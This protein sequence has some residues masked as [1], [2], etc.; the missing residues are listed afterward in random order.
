MS[1]SESESENPTQGK[2]RKPKSEW[3]GWNEEMVKE[4]RT[5]LGAT[6]Q[7]DQPLTAT[8]ATAAAIATKMNLTPEQIKVYPRAALPHCFLQM[9]RNFEYK[10]RRR[11]TV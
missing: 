11:S 7:V 6:A 3:L 2:S 1:E 4:L 8:K 5:L 10:F 9:Q